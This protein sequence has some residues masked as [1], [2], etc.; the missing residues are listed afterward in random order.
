MLL[1]TE[2]RM[3]SSPESLSFGARRVGRVVGVGVFLFLGSAHAQ[4][5]AIADE[6]PSTHAPTQS[7]KPRANTFGEGA[8][9]QGPN[10]IE[11]KEDGEGKRP[12]ADQT[13]PAT[14][15][16]SLG[17]TDDSATTKTIHSKVTGV[18][19]HC[20]IRQPNAGRAQ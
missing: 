7:G 6:T 10:R 3:N 13:S 15:S 8:S 4:T 14:S 19:V 16:G 18:D 12:A 11:T 9:G 20:H 5:E 2:N 17:G 1:E